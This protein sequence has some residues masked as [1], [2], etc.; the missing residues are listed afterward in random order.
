M[1]LGRET[2]LEQHVFHHVAAQSLRHAQLL[3]PGRFECQVLVGMA[4]QHVVEAPLWRSEHARYAHFPAQGDIGKAHAPAG[5]ITS[6]P[7]LARARIGRVAVGAQG[8]AVDEG[9]G[10]GREHLLA[11][12]PHQLGTNGGRG[13]LHQNHVIEAD[14]VEGIFQCQHTLDLMSHDHGCK[15][16]THQQRRLTRSYVLL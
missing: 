8:L 13:H 11:I 7:G 16:I 2:D 3:L 9:M 15:H 12:G 6:G 5:S 4:E 14:A 10:Q 1:E